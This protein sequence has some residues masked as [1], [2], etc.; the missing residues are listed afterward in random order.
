MPHAPSFFD[1]LVQDNLRAR[2]VQ[3]ISSFEYSVRLE[4]LGGFFRDQ[5]W[6]HMHAVLRAQGIDYEE[7]GRRGREAALDSLVAE[8]FSREEASSE[9]GHRGRRGALAS[10]ER[11]GFTEEGGTKTASQ[12][13]AS[14]GRGGALA[15]LYTQG[16]TGEGGT[17]TASEELAS[18]GGWATS[19]IYRE[20]GNCSYPGC[21]YAIRCSG[22]C[23]KH[24]PT[25]PIVEKSDKCRVCGQVFQGRITAGVCNPCYQKPDA[26]AARKKAIAEKKAARGTCAIP[27]CNNLSLNGRDKCRNCLYPRKSK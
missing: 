4:E 12:E 10:L 13:L 11:Q 23:K 16:F 9:L 27:G 6:M 24:L 20:S 17:K 5:R 2:Y 22:F 25:K 19:A 15:S 26:V 14:R 18:R 21:T 7:L 8:G 3:D 1:T